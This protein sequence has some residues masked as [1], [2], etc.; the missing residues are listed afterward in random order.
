MFEFKHP[1]YWADL[2]KEKRAQA[3]KL[4]G[5]KRCANQQALNMIPIIDGHRPRCFVVP[6]QFGE[7]GALIKFY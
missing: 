7:R 2:R 4:S 1:K 5:G 3:L 6:K